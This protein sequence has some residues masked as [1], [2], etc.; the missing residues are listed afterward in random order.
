MS[1]TT[2]KEFINVISEKAVANKNALKFGA[3]GE[4][5]GNRVRDEQGMN[6]TFSNIFGLANNFYDYNGSHD[7]VGGAMNSNFSAAGYAD[8]SKVTTMG[9]IDVSIKIYAKSLVP[10]VAVDR[11]LQDPEATVY[12]MDLVAT[13]NVN[14][15][16]AGDTVVSNFAPIESPSLFSQTVK[17][18]AEAAEFTATGVELN[19]ST[20][21]VPG[22]V[23][24]RLV[25]GGSEAKN[26]EDATEVRHGYDYN[27]DG[28]IVIG[29]VAVEGTV[30]YKGTDGSAGTVSI[31]PVVIDAL[32]GW[33]RVIV[34]AEEDATSITDANTDGDAQLTVKPEWVSISLKTR[35]KLI[36]LQQNIHAN[37]VIQ[38]IQARAATMGATSNYTGMAFNRITSLYMEDINSDLIRLLV[39]MAHVPENKDIG[40]T[41][42]TLADYN[43]GHLEYRNETVE[44]MIRRF[45]A[46]MVGDFVKRT[47]LSPTVCITGT[48]G[49]IELSTNMSAFVPAEG[50]NTVQNGYIGTYTG[51]PVFRHILIDRMEETQFGP[52]AIN[53]E[54]GANY[55]DDTYRKVAT[56]YLATKCL[57]NNCGSLVIGEF[58]PLTQ[59]STTSNFQNLTQVASGFFSQIGMTPIQKKLIKK[60]L[61]SYTDDVTKGV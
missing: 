19:L 49:G 5:F 7:M 13:N 40:V 25:K 9:A 54:T 34:E 61:I 2:R 59:M 42:L 23:H 8:V 48:K 17:A 57:D 52:R 36:T 39:H 33:D 60:G 50:A 15:V 22:K 27:A 37:A 11:A 55:K 47:N 43:G 58:L 18:V 4:K 51:I 41:F 24:I 46:E 45:F 30:S 56:F 44:H 1:K 38:K 28:K 3:L 29:G 31:K 26:W 53:P 12:Y 21:L 32:T 14:G 35:P 20:L 6:V 10:H 16:K